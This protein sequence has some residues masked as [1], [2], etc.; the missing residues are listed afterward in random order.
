MK[1]LLLISVISLL[2]VSGWSHVLA[3]AFCPNMQDMPGCPMQQ[4]ASA[5]TSRHEGH[6][7]MEMGDGQQLKPAV[8]EGKA[9][10]LERP[11]ASCCVS[12]PEIPPAPVVASRGA[13]QSKQDLGAILKPATKAI[14]P[15][16]CALARPVMSRQ[17]APPPLASAPRYVLI[18]VFLI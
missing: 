17:H 10:A 3:A 4:T 18:S 14:A 11:L 2:F 8:T 5:S 6:E 16:A 13:E 1:R 15:H 12:L 9:G 7:G